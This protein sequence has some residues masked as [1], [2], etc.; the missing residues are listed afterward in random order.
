[1]K[2][3]CPKCLKQDTTRYCPACGTEMFLPE[4]FEQAYKINGTDGA[5]LNLIK[6]IHTIIWCIFVAAILYVLYAGI[7]DRVNIWTW[8]CIG[9]V[10]IEGVV[11][12]ICKGKCP[13]TILGYKY[14]DDT[15]VGFDIFLP[16]WLAK[17]NKV[18]FSIIFVIGLGLVL[19]RV[20]IQ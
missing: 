6:F 10:F 8:I 15:Q 5:K 18:I 7:F 11:L 19:W 3:K 16:A 9:F 17:H 1:M 4:R 14:A 2:K 13:F 12:L 20:F